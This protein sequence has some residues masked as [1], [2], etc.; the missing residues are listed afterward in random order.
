[1]RAAGS[2][3]TSMF[4]CKTILY[5]RGDHMFMFFSRLWVILNH[6]DA[7]LITARPPE[8][9]HVWWLRRV[10]RHT[11]F[12][13]WPTWN[14]P[15]W[16]VCNTLCGR[17]SPPPDI[18]SVQLNAICPSQWSRSLRHEMSSNA[19]I[20]GSNPTQ[21]MDVCVYSVCI[22]GGLA[23][24]WSPI[25]GVLPNV[26]G[27]RNLSGTKR[28]TDAP[29]S[30]V[31][32][33]GKREKENVICMSRAWNYPLECFVAASWTFNSYLKRY[34]NISLRSSYCHVF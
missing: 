7:W 25:Q 16:P 33:T 30:K 8:R 17:N 10:F 24:G 34:S 13:V 18:N 29:C 11:R 28:F 31:G 19:G 1:M 14:E 21:G 12:V 15:G 9:R 6:V 20:V 26:L 2:S 23:K 3:E 27:L 32:A 5:N 4:T 22:G